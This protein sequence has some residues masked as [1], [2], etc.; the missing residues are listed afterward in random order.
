MNTRTT[1]AAVVMAAF[2]AQGCQ[3]KPDP[4]AERMKAIEE[5]MDKQREA[6]GESKTNQMR[7]VELIQERDKL[8]D[9]QIEAMHEEIFGM[10]SNLVSGLRQMENA[11]AA[12]PTARYVAPSQPMAYKDG[13]PLTDYN[14]IASKA[15]QQWPGN[16][17]MQVI[18][19]NMQ[20]EAY[21]KLAH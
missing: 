8:V 20:V 13:I 6:M 15:A 10:H 18:Y 3:K 14:E 12:R 5:R 11:V 2:L 7:L 19:I 1:V 9:I 17:D 4:L 16:Y 21:K